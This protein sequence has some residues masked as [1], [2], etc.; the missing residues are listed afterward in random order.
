M[1]SLKN[2]SSN[3]ACPAALK[4]PAAAKALAL[5]AAEATSERR[6]RDGMATHDMIPSQ[7]TL[8]ASVNH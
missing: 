5:R 3:E 7:Q 6:V 2:I 4:T 1:D 8:S